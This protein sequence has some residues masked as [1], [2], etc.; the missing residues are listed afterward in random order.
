MADK[1]ARYTGLSAKFILAANLRVDSGR[2]RKELL[3]DKRLVVGRL[4]G[5]FTA[6]DADAA[7]ERQEFDPSNTA[8]PGRLRRRCSRTTSRTI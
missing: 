7:G 3:R 8:L 4:D 1:L 5:R 6:L 2:F